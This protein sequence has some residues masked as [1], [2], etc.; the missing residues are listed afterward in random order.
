M[1]KLP[2]RTDGESNCGQWI[3][4]VLVVSGILVSSPK[5]TSQEISDI[6]Y[7]LTPEATESHNRWSSHRSVLVMRT[8]VFFDFKQEDMIDKVPSLRHL[9]GG[10]C[11]D[12]R[13]LTANDQYSL[14]RLMEKDILCGTRRDK[15]N[16]GYSFEG[17]AV[18]L[19]GFKFDDALPLW[20]KL[21]RHLDGDMRNKDLDQPMIGQDKDSIV[22]TETTHEAFFLR[23]L[24]L[25]CGKKYGSIEEWTKSSGPYP[26]WIDDLMFDPRKHTSKK[27]QSD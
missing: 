27:I 19:L 23:C 4:C 20:R 25:K 12:G 1:S 2:N 13:D 7:W 21:A 10:E 26:T 16:G 14:A 8:K 18:Y 6:P 15:L 9:I 5:C 11:P 3:G 17:W 24:V 22:W